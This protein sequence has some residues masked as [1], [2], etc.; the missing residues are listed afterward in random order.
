METW[1]S[2]YQAAHADGPLQWLHNVEFGE[3]LEENWKSV[4]LA[5][6]EVFP[7]LEAVQPYVGGAHARLMQCRVLSYVPNDASIRSFDTFE[8]LT[9]ELG[10][11]TLQ[12]V[13]GA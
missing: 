9:L 3:Q 8:V 11:Q 13:T 4:R 5:E 2:P 12:R 6:N 1:P 10:P 7:L